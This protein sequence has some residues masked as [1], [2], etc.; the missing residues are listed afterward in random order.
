M[1]GAA[2]T[3]QGRTEEAIATHERMAE[4]HPW[5]R[6]MLGTTYA[7]AGRTEDALRVARELEEAG[8]SSLDAF[9]LA[10]LY[11]ALGDV[12]ETYRWATFE[13]AHA[14]LVGLAIDPIASVPR[15]I[16]RDPRFDDLMARMDLPWWEG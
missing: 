3:A 6:W 11:G 9:G 5:L 7:R 2:L 10:V 16:L 13:P 12:D 15:E 8:P 14:W 1:L 4:V